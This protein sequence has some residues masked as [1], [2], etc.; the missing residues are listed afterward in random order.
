MKSKLCFLSVLGMLLLFAANVNAQV[1]AGSFSVSPFAGYSMFSYDDIL[2]DAATYG[3]SFGYN[4][5]ENFGI[6]VSYNNI[7]TEIYSKG[8]THTEGQGPD[9]HTVVD[10]PAG[11]DVS[12]DQWRFEGLFY[13]YPG[14]KFAPYAAIGI[15]QIDYDYGGTLYAGQDKIGPSSFKDTNVPLG[16]GCKYFVTENIA[17][18]ADFRDVYFMPGNNLLLTAGVTFQFGGE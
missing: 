18:R 9:E 4:F 6:E 14:K 15:G 17:I 2:D 12:G 3:V 10:I 11:T 8:A 13:I 5:S 7:D 1:T 16:F